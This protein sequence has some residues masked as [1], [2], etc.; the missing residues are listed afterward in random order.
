M[1]KNVPSYDKSDI[2]AVY[3]RGDW[4]SW[5]DIVKWLEKGLQHDEQADNEL[6]EK[7][8]HELLDDFRR[9]QGNGTPFTGDPAEAYRALQQAR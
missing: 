6:S 2:E 5:G 3:R 7:E 1:G 9:L 8:S 4:S